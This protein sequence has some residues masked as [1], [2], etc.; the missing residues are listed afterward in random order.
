MKL[1]KRVVELLVALPVMFQFHHGMRL[2]VIAG[3]EKV[4]VSTVRVTVV[5]T[6]GLPETV[7]VLVVVHATSIGV[8]KGS[9]EKVVMVDKVD[10]ATIMFSGAMPVAVFESGL[11]TSVAT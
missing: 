7:T 2:V 1:G 5:V 10:G 9:M 4:V 11:S 6:V 3:M 8:T